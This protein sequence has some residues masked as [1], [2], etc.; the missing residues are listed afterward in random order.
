M[1]QPSHSSSTAELPE[2][3]DPEVASIDEEPF[4][5]GSGKHSRCQVLV[6]RNKSPSTPRLHYQPAS[7]E[8]IFHMVCLKQ[9][10]LKY[11]AHLAAREDSFWFRW[12]EKFNRNFYGESGEPP[13]YER[14][15]LLHVPD[16]G[17]PCEYYDQDMPFVPLA[18]MKDKDY[19]R[20]LREHFQLGIQ[21]A[22]HRGYVFR[23]PVDTF[24]CPKHSEHRERIARDLGL[25][26]IDGAWR[27]SDRL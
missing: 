7:P 14:Q 22:R 16:Q 20:S 26:I 21:L 17:D 12:R 2:N 5:L 24:L 6:S 27:L 23:E 10:H 11:I 25:V 8:Q 18:S 15:A 19:N 3:H 9:R 1:S 4:S 13:D